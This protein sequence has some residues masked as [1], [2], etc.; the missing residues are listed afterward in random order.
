MW[1]LV[2][3]SAWGGALMV[4]FVFGNSQIASSSHMAYTVFATWY[5]QLTWI[6]QDWPGEA[7]IF[8][9]RATPPYI[10]SAKDQKSDSLSQPIGMLLSWPLLSSHNL[11][12]ASTIKYLKILKLQCQGFSDPK[13]VLFSVCL[14]QLPCFVGKWSILYYWWIHYTCDNIIWCSPLVKTFCLESL[15]P[16]LTIVSTAVNRTCHFIIYGLYIIYINNTRLYFNR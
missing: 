2:P 9:Q 7:N 14:P 1:R 15:L 6:S 12:A 3:R 5:Q 10:K 11:L 13:C 16:V 8:F 4:T